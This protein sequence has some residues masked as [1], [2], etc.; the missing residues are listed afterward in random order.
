[1]LIDGHP[2]RRRLWKRRWL[3]PDGGHTCHS[4]PSEDVPSLRSCALIVVLKL[5]APRCPVPR[6][7]HPRARPTRAAAAR[8]GSR[9]LS[10]RIAVPAGWQAACN[11]RAI[12]ARPATISP[13]SIACLLA[14]SARGAAR[15][16]RRCARVVARCAGSCAGVAARHARGDAR[17]A[18]RLPRPSARARARARLDRRAVRSRRLSRA[19][20]ASDR[21]ARC[22]RRAER[23]GG[24]SGA[25]PRGSRRRR[26]RAVAA[27]QPHP[28]GH[29][30]RGAGPLSH[31]SASLAPGAKEPGAGGG[32][33]DAGATA[34]ARRRGG[35]QACSSF[36][37]RAA[38]ERH[39][40]LGRAERHVRNVGS[41]WSRR[42]RV[43]W[44]SRDGA[45][46]A[47]R[48]GQPRRDAQRSLCARRQA[49]RRFV[50]PPAR[51]SPA[52]TDRGLPGLPRV[53][54]VEPV[55]ACPDRAARR[56]APLGRLGGRAHGSPR[57]RS[58]RFRAPAARV[59]E[60]AA[61]AGPAN[62]R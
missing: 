22:G 47:R 53:E 5:W 48:R 55:C 31:R 12:D 9:S 18:A 56:A 35:A 40:I 39:R 10:P 28:S 60:G 23:R 59:G 50:R 34:R 33:G 30:A 61:L 17:V 19:C 11:Q 13:V 21:G 43:A 42:G 26:G 6:V 32:R 37:R 20:R 57:A 38:H 49:G 1:M 29:Q 8:A 24:G 62:R 41:R 36:A 3:S 4:W 46:P 7:R 54:P 2:V 14:G 58:R 16:A 44:R 52:P 51:S 15:C 27:A 45:Q 25:G